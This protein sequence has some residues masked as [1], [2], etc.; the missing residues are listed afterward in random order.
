VANTHR[1]GLQ[2]FFLANHPKRRT[3]KI[4]RY[5]SNSFHICRLCLHL[6]R[7][8]RRVHLLPHPSMQTIPTNLEWYGLKSH[9]KL[10]VILWPLYFSF[11]FF[12]L[13]YIFCGFFKYWFI[14]LSSFFLSWFMNCLILVWKSISCFSFWLYFVITFIKFEYILSTKVRFKNR[15]EIKTRWGCFAIK[16]YYITFRISIKKIKILPVQY[17]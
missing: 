11:I 9:M 7:S 4:M 16:I 6:S 15:I 14:G 13:T 3:S 1:L 8:V 2:R 17:Y 5:Q 10:I 12:Y